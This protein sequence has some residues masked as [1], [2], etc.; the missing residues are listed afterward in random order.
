MTFQPQG[1]VDVVEG[2]A[3]WSDR[4]GD[5]D[6]SKAF[7]VTE[8]VAGLVQGVADDPMDVDASPADDDGRLPH[9]CGHIVQAGTELARG[10]PASC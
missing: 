4:W 10:C 8:V 6:L 2:D 9:G 5:S 3:V 1:R 7:H